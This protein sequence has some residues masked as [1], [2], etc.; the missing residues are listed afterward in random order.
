MW[1]HCYVTGWKSWTWLVQ[2]EST[3]PKIWKWPGDE[4]RLYDTRL[5]YMYLVQYSSKLILQCDA[6][7]KLYKIYC[8][9]DVATCSAFT[10]DQFVSHNT[11]QTGMQGP[12]YRGGV[13]VCQLQHNL[14]HR[15]LYSCEM[16][17]SMHSE[18]LILGGWVRG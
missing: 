18:M 9:A 8:I 14:L 15:S 11:L 6:C 7:S 4:A 12:N 13:A 2:T 10:L 3:L 5:C 1:D 16:V 17:I